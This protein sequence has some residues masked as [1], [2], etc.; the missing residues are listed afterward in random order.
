VAAENEPTPVQPTADRSAAKKSCAPKQKREVLPK[1]Q[2]AVDLLSREGGV[3]HKQLMEATGWHKTFRAW[4]HG[5][6]EQGLIAKRD[7]LHD[8]RAKEGDADRLHNRKA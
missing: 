3:T 4:R 6:S 8:K 2:I 1:K 5:Q 7:S